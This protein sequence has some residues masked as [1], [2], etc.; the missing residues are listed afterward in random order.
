MGL[1][2]TIG[3]IL[4]D[5]T[6]TGVNETGIPQFA[7]NPGGA[8]ANVAVAASRLGA[9]TAFLGCIGQDGFG[10]F[11]RDTLRRQ[12]VD[13]TGLAETPDAPTTLAVVNIDKNGERRFQFYRKPGADTCLSREMLLPD[14]LEEAS[15]LHFGSVSLTA[16][17]S[18]DAVQY[19][20]EYAK[21][22]GALITYDPN[23]R[24][25]LWS[26]EET[27]IRA[28]RAMLPLVDVI[29]I[30]DEETALL[31]DHA[32]PEDAAIALEAQGIRLVL[33]TLGADGVLYRYQ[34]RTGQ[35]PGFSVTVVDTNGAGDTF[36]GAVLSRL[37]DLTLEELTETDLRMILRMANC[38]AA[39]TTSHPGAIPA[40]PT[41]VEVEE[42]LQKED[43]K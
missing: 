31:T 18:R 39:L 4:I 11:L 21:D 20:A 8:P 15:I 28:M 19:A 23:Y 24:A 9:R 12:D 14:P 2:V 34:G 22:H 36:F 33:V 3:E 26:D 13:V 35:V 17:P 41:L 25:N 37:T 7:A 43:G 42:K 38:A 29:K 6:Q 1:L 5:L 40:M 10:A 27:A 30:S 16:A 32:N